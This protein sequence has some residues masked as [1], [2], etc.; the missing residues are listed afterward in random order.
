MTDHGHTTNLPYHLP[1]PH[2][3]RSVPAGSQ[4]LVLSSPVNCYVFV[5]LRTEIGVERGQN[6]LGSCP[7]SAMIRLFLRS[8]QR[9]RRGT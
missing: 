1:T 2:P 7:F 9:V 8:I 4:M 6:Y 3:R 5:L